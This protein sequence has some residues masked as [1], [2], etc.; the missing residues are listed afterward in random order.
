M[1]VASQGQ[2]GFD[3]G[4]AKFIEAQIYNYLN[5]IAACH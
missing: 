3:R 5:C 2:V 4:L 1:P